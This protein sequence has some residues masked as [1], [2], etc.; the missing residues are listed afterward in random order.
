LESVA[1]ETPEEHALRARLATLAADEGGPLTDGIPARWLQDPTW[2]CVNQHVTTRFAQ[3]RR[4][5]RVCV[6]KHVDQ[7]VAAT[8]PEDRS[9]PLPDTRS[10][11]PGQPSAPTAVTT[12]RSL[13]LR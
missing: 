10:A 5:C 11:I 2:R 12:P 7:P 1:K 4:G 3:G 9:E 8:F 13:R 6:F